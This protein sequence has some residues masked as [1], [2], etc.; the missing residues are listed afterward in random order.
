MRLESDIVLGKVI[1]NWSFL[2]IL[3]LMT[4]LKVPTPMPFTSMFVLEYDPEVMK[5]TVVE[6]T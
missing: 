4:K 5:P 2:F 1:K 3:E 6:D